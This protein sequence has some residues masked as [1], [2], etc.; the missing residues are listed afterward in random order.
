MEQVSPDLLHAIAWPLF[1]F[2]IGLFVLV[3]EV[4]SPG[5]AGL[6]SNLVNNIPAA[7]LAR[8]ILQ[9]AHAHSPVIYSVLIGM[10]IG[11]NLTLFGSLATMMVLT[12][13]RKKGEDIRGL[14]F[15]KV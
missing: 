3:R 10:N 1:P 5:L 12:T 14:D 8:D 9:T 2:V 7:L 13:A 15:F 4:E 11:P 6:A